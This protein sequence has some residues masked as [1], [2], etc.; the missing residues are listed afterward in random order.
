MCLKGL[1]FQDGHAS[2]DETTINPGLKDSVYEATPWLQQ[3]NPWGHLHIC[4]YIFV[5][6]YNNTLMQGQVVWD[7]GGVIV[8]RFAR[9]T[10]A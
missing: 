7:T 3:Q 8:N 4:Q 6:P 5:L 1:V 10:G 2:I 9:T